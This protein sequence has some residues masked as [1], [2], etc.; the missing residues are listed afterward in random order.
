MIRAIY[1]LDMGWFT[2]RWLA[3]YP[4]G[5]DGGHGPRGWLQDEGVRVCGRPGD[6]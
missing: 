1:N 5:R 6:V 3:T 2:L 4:D